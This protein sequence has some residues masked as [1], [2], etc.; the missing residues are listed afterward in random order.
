MKK[1]NKIFA[2]SSASIVLMHS[3]MVLPVISEAETQSNNEEQ[4][5]TSEF[6]ELSQ[7]NKTTSK[8]AALKLIN[9]I[10]KRA[11]EFRDLWI[12]YPAQTW[13]NAA[14]HQQ[15]LGTNNTYPLNQG[16]HQTGLISLLPGLTETDRN[17]FRSSQQQ[18]STIT[19][20]PFKGTINTDHN[21]F[22]RYVEKARSNVNNSNSITIDFNEVRQTIETIKSVITRQRNAEVGLGTFITTH[23]LTNEIRILNLLLDDIKDIE[24]SV[25]ADKPVINA[26]NKEIYVN[27]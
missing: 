20:F 3:M 22:L 4:V 24:N 9:S 11:N 6:S 16:G 18:V 2:I 23:F 21:N 25:E 10:E 17:N 12:N 13:I 19:L 5:A 7:M 14:G 27:G 15:D 8:S 26:S 1:I